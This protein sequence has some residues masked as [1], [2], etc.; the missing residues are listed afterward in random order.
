MSWLS[1]YLSLCAAVH[2]GPGRR[3]QWCR[4]GELCGGQCLQNSDSQALLRGSLRP[5]PC[6][7]L[8]APALPSRK[9][10]CSCAPRSGPKTALV[11]IPGPSP[12]P[13]KQSWT[14]TGSGREGLLGPLSQAGSG[15]FPPPHRRVQNSPDALKGHVDLTPALSGK[16]WEGQGPGAHLRN[17]WGLESGRVRRPGED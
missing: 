10:P 4:A 9:R 15:S 11:P 17:R 13:C 12:C 14:G 8:P 7:Q 2:G 16:Q 6:W 1:P 5:H 3:P